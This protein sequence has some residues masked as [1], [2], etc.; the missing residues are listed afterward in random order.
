M[1]KVT[2]IIRILLGALSNQMTHPPHPH[3]S[4]ASPFGSK[5]YSL[6]GEGVGRPNSDE[7][8]DTLVLYVNYNPSTSLA[9][10]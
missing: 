8:T 2:K 5:T 7:G 4:F 6:A 9:T 10:P 1:Q 3:A